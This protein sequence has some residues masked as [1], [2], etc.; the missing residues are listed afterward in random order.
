MGTVRHALLIGLV[1]A[2]VAGGGVAYWGSGGLL[3]CGRADRL[4]GFSDCESLA[5]FDDQELEALT[6]APGGRLLAVERAPGRAPTERQQLL[7]IDPRDGRVISRT[8]LPDLAPAAIWI[9][10][11]VSPSGRRIAGSFLRE[12]PRVF[13]LASGR[14]VQTIE[15]G[16]SQVAFL[17][18]DVVLLPASREK[19]RKGTTWRAH[20]Q[21]YAVADGKATK[22]ATPAAP[23]LFSTGV[24][25]ALSPN[26]A[27]AAVHEKV[28]GGVGIALLR[29]SDGRRIRRLTGPIDDSDPSLPEL[30]FSPNGRL[31]AASFWS[32]DRW[33]EER[34]ALFVWDTASGR[35]LRRL[36]TVDQLRNLTWLPDS[37]ALLATGYD[38]DARRT[39]LVRIRGS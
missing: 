39:Q 27:V 31:L 12:Q 15:H 17:D 23:W 11:A 29:A 7:G 30:A 21:G 3:P 24:S 19:A 36:P 13:D 8:T 28:P 9:A 14:T 1:L 22:G 35:L 26:G 25:E 34:T 18:E 5:V 20:T 4:A 16:G 37:S 2:L 6:M 32:V 33:F 38:S 10:L